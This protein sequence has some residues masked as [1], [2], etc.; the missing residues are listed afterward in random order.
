MVYINRFPKNETLKKK[1]IINRK[2]LEKDSKTKL[3]VP[4]PAA[5]MCT[6]HFEEEYIYWC[7]KYITLRDGAIPIIFI[8]S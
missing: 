7:G 8:K 2:Q 4:G 6:S 3:V 1:W 5:Q